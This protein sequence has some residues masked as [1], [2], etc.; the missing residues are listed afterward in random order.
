MRNGVGI[1]ISGTAR[2]PVIDRWFA[3]RY[4][5][6][7]RGAMLT[8]RLS[9][10]SDLTIMR[11]GKKRSDGRVRVVLRDI[12]NLFLGEDIFKGD[13]SKEPRKALERLYGS[14]FEESRYDEVLAACRK[15]L[16][17]LPRFRGRFLESVS[18]LESAVSGILSNTGKNPRKTD[19]EWERLGKV[20]DSME[21]D[22][23]KTF[24]IRPVLMGARPA[25]A[26]S[27]QPIVKF[28]L[29]A[30]SRN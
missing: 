12:L 24:R 22:F 17:K 21:R 6:E 26:P 28:V 4:Q 7:G 2:F 16:S 1:F 14:P 3:R 8:A 23:G 30:Y 25:I 27:D 29:H 10:E 15:H 19:E 18:E 5:Y 9:R 11:N 20:L 13:G